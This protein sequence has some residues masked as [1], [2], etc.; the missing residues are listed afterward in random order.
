EGLR[1]E[2]VPDLRAAA[3]GAL[4]QPVV[5]AGAGV[6]DAV[7][8]APTGGLVPLVGPLRRL[9]LGRL[10]PAGGGRDRPGGPGGPGGL[11]RPGLRR[12]VPGSAHAA[13]RG[14]VTARARPAS[15]PR[16]PLR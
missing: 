6:D 11:G 13:A 10:L 14:T 16:S 4:V 9:L 7:R 3:A 12:A 1:G 15:P 8:G 2:R 5:T